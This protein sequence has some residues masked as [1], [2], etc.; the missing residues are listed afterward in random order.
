MVMHGAG[1][2]KVTIHWAAPRQQ[3][4]I[5]LAKHTGK[6]CTKTKGLRWVKNKQETVQSKM[7][8]MK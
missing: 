3:G 1:R 4:F 2:K 5:E 8:I 6:K 7:K